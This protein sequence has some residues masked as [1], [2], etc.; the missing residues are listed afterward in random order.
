MWYNTHNVFY[1][2]DMPPEKNGRFLS[3]KIRKVIMFFTDTP[4][5]R[6]VKS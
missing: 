1:L 6:A 4:C 2:K 5:F 3:V